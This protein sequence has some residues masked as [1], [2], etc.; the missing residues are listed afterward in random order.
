[1][2]AMFLRVHRRS[3]RLYSIAVD[4]EWQGHGLGQRLM[5][6]AMW[7]A[8]QLGK[9]SLYLEV[10]AMNTKLVGWYQEQGYKEEA[11]L[12]DY[13]GPAMDALRMRRIVTSTEGPACGR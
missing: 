7:R 6:H 5:R 13:Y 2:A 3:L 4:P 12:R 1:M 9:G 8:S 10:E 11:C